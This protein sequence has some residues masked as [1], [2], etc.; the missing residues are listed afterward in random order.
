VSDPVR[1]L[2]RQVALWLRTTSD[3]LG[4]H[5]KGFRDGS[6]P[7][8]N[9][10]QHVDVKR[11]QVLTADLSDF[12]GTIT[13]ADVMREF[14]A[15]GAARPASTLLARLCCIDERLMQGGRASAVIANLVAKRLD[16]IIIRELNPACTYTRYVD[17]LTISGA[18]DSMPSVEQLTAWIQLADFRARPD[19]VILKSRAAGPYVTGL[20][21]AGDRPRIP[22]RLRRKIERYLR[23]SARFD[24]E[25]AARRT[26]KGGRLT[27]PS[28]VHRWIRGMANWVRPID[29]ELA[30]GWDNS[31]DELNEAGSQP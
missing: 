16:T 8:E 27:D 2:Q 6:C 23:F 20:S 7:L 28:E 21:V 24:E 31:L 25:T 10:R 12:F 4:D 29:K 1:R 26:F 13:I 15:L 22:R 11:D 14:E 18:T 3:A 30:D 17:D 19:S 5:V 9:A